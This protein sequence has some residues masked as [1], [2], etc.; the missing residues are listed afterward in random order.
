MPFNIYAGFQSV[1]GGV[2]C[3]GGNNNTSYTKKYQ[4]HIPCSFAYKIF[5]IDEKFSKP[6]V[7]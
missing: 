7:L 3:S 6:V 2:R 4:K 1:L 5:F